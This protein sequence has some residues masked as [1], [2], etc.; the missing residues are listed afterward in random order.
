[1]AQRLVLDWQLGSTA[2]LANGS[3]S[4]SPPGSAHAVRPSLARQPHRHRMRLTSGNWKRVGGRLCK[5]WLAKVRGYK[6]GYGGEWGLIL[7]LS[8][9]GETIK[10]S[11]RRVVMGLDGTGIESMTFSIYLKF[12]TPFFCL[13]SLPLVSISLAF[14]LC[15]AC[16]YYFVLFSTHPTASPCDIFIV[17]LFFPFFLC[18][19]Q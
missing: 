18:I 15:N 13:P 16:W 19:R 12:I 5:W 6:C 11:G 10:R 9:T 1:M 7:P 2:H 8:R 4:V 14:S 3:Y 17:F